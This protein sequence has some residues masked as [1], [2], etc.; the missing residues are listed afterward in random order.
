M[1]NQP[2]G[3]T[4]VMV[5]TGSPDEEYGKIVKGLNTRAG[6]ILVAGA[7]HRTDIPYRK[8]KDGIQIL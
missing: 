1:R 8:K 4:G 6:I 7:L 5:F 2:V 3:D